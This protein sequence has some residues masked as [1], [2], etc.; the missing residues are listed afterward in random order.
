MNEV[1]KT[2][3]TLPAAKVHSD[4]VDSVLKKVNDLMTLG[5]L[6]LPKDYSPENALKGAYLVLSEMKDQTS[7]K[8][9]LDVVTKA[10]VANSLL[11]M[12][13]EGL[14]V[15]KGQGNFIKYGNELQWQREYDGTI[16]LA[17][18]LGGVVG[19]PVGVIVYKDDE[20][21]Y[22]IDPGSGEIVILKHTQKLT[23]MKPDSIVG[24]YA[25][26]KLSNGET[27]T[28]L[29]TMDMVRK[30][31]EQG[32]MKG[33]SPAHK[34]FPDQ[35]VKKTVISRACKLF[36]SSSDDSS[37]GSDDEPIQDPVV[38][39]SKQAKDQTSTISVTFDEVMNE[40]PGY[41]EIKPDTGPGMDAP[42]QHTE[43]P[44]DG[45]PDSAQDES[46]MTAGAKDLFNE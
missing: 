13:V 25:I 30:A 15:L 33:N 34:N 40:G 5:E 23:N 32:A 42:K 36:I 28:E 29:M 10:S 18:R 2:A 24:A 35:M 46:W 4:I 8:P 9:I 7:K 12:I 17:K 21:E 19:V 11:R 44:L 1:Q 26:V 38:I 20:F 3:S 14:S 39:A 6:R 16:A 45:P 43:R 31:W 22:S 27:H 37:L 41:T